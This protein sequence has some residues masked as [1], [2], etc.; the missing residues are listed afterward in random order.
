MAKTRSP[1]RPI[2]QQMRAR[3]PMPSPVAILT[4]GDGLGSPPTSTGASYA[5]VTLSA[6]GGRRRA[7]AA[8]RRP[9][10][11]RRGGGS[12]AG[13]A[14]SSSA[15][16]PMAVS[17]SLPNSPSAK[18]PDAQSS[19]SCQ[20]DTGLLRRLRVHQARPRHPPDQGSDRPAGGL[21]GGGSVAEEL[22]HALMVESAPRTPRPVGINRRGAPSRLDGRIRSSDP[23]ASWY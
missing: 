12:A 13:S 21:L 7:R 22:L 20:S 9:P 4:V 16:A 18:S 5:R 8:R 14:R 11:A 17:S 3:A 6:G 1:P 19:S 15:S 2:A 23:A 10:R